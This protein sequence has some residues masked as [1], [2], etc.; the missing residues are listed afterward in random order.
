[1]PHVLSWLLFHGAGLECA[2][3]VF[4]VGPATKCI[5]YI[6]EFFKRPD[7]RSLDSVETQNLGVA[8]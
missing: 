4:V 5:F 7:P 3:T 6:K 8:G 2:T 1:M